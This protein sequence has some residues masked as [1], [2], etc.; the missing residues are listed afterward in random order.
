MRLALILIAAISVAGAAPAAAPVATESTAVALANGQIDA[1]THDF[2]SDRFSPTRVVNF[3][4]D[5]AAAEQAIAKAHGKPS[6]ADVRAARLCLKPSEGMTLAGYESA[7]VASNAAAW[8]GERDAANAAF[9]RF[10]KTRDAVLA[11]DP[12]PYPE[13]KPAADAVADAR[14]A[15]APEVHDLFQRKARDL[16][17]RAGIVYGVPKAY[18]EG[19]GK[20]GAIWLNARIATLG[21]DSDAE[22]AAW[23]KSTLQTLT[24]FDIKTYGKDADAAAWLIAQHADADPDLQGL[25]LERMGRLALVRQ[26]NPANFAFLWDRVALAQGRPQ[27]YGTQMRCIG[28]L[29]SPVTPIEEVAQLDTRRSWVGLGPFAGVQRTGAKVCGG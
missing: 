26:S 9:D 15:T 11:G 27:R 19:V 1:M 22:N 13:F 28:K 8:A 24:W 5:K 10:L 6:I 20:A 29:W 2:A 21:C 17:W 7:L 14:E 3:L 23:L 4:G 12:A 16:I 25:A 18:A